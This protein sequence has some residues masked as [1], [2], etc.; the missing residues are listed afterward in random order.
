MCVPGSKISCFS[1]TNFTG[2]QS[3]YVD[4][5]CW[6]SLTH[7]EFDAAGNAIAKSLWTLKVSGL[8]G[9]ASSVLKGHSQTPKHM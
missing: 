1:P 7:L 6:D 8:L 3:A 5:S 9:W 4:T 2:K